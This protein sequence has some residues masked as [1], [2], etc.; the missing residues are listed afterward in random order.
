V[1]IFFSARNLLNDR[2]REFFRSDAV[3]FMLSGGINYEF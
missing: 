3:P 2:S 1:H